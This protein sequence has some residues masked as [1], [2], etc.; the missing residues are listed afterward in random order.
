M[1]KAKPN[2]TDKPKESEENKKNANHLA[3]ENLARIR[4][5]QH[6][7]RLK[8]AELE[9]AKGEHKLVKQQLELERG[10]LAKLIEVTEAGHVDPLFAETDDVSPAQAVPKDLDED[11]SWKDV[12]LSEVFSGL[13]KGLQQKV[14]DGGL[15]TLNDVTEHCKHKR[16]TDILGVGQA[17]A[18]KLQAAM[19]DFWQR[20]K[21]LAT[22]EAGK[23]ASQD[24][25]STNGPSALPMATAE[26]LGDEE[27]PL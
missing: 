21:E 8:E 6:K 15:V 23:Q 4:A 20:R 16:L 2:T 25:P 24:E 13:P 17:N 26:P 10:K 14:L 7:V 19:D 3:E 12:L 5:M 18:D 1:A 11:D 9:R 22:A 27:S